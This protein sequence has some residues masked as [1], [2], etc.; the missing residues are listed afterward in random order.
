M[1]RYIQGSFSALEH[2]GV[3]SIYI[4]ATDITSFAEKEQ[5]LR[6]RIASLQELVS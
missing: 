3:I 5:T 2:D 4:T 1:K 6:D